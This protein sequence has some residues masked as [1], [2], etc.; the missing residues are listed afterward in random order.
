[1]G[2]TMEGLER[3]NA[4]VGDFCLFNHLRMNPVK[5]QLTGRD[6]KGGR[7]EKGVQVEGKLVEPVGMGHP[8]SGGQHSHGHEHHRPRGR[9][10]ENGGTPRVAGC[11]TPPRA[12]S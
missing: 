6:E 1:M 11:K 5:T 3:M 4:F 10:H 8:V 12:F 7:M 9:D 2:E